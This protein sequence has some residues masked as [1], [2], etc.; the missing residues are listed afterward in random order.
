MIECIILESPSAI[1]KKN[2]AAKM[3]E[4]LDQIAFRANPTG[5]DE[6]ITLW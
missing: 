6:I 3:A 5:L 2:Y 4:I 1:L